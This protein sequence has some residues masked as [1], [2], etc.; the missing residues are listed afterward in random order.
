MPPAQGG[1]QASPALPTPIATPPIANI[2]AS[3]AQVAEMYAQG[4]PVP[5]GTRLIDPVTLLEYGQ[6]DGAGGYQLTSG[7]ITRYTAAQLSAL[8]AAGGLT[9]YATYVESD[10]GIWR[11]AT[12][13]T[14][15]VSFSGG[16]G[17][18]ADPLTLENGAFS[19]TFTGPGGRFSLN[20]QSVWFPLRS[21]MPGVAG[22]RP[23]VNWFLNSS[24]PG[25]PTAWDLAVDGLADTYAA[26]T[27]AHAGATIGALTVTNAASDGGP[28]EQGYAGNAYGAAA[29]APYAP[30]QWYAYNGVP[31]GSI[32]TMRALA[33]TVTAP[34][35][36]VIYQRFRDS[37]IAPTESLGGTITLSAS[38]QTFTATME[39]NHNYPALQ[40]RVNLLA[41]GSGD[42]RLAHV[43]LEDLTGDKGPL[44]PGEYVPS[45]ASPGWQWFSTAKGTSC[46]NS[47]YTANHA[48][49]VGVKNPLI[50]SA[51][52][53]GVLTD[54]TGARL[55]GITG[56]VSEPAATNIATGFNTLASIGVAKASGAIT[57]FPGV[58][59]A[60]GSTTARYEASSGQM[61]G[62]YNG[63]S[64]TDITLTLNGVSAGNDSIDSTTTNFV[65]AGFFVGMTI[66]VWRSDTL[67]FGPMPVASVT[68]TKIGLTGTFFGSTRASGA[69]TRILRCPGNGDNI[70]LMLNDGTAHHTTLASAVTLPS[71]GAWD[72]K[73]PV[74]M[75]LAAAPPSNG[76][77]ASTDNGT[78]CYYWKDHT[79]FGVSFTG[80]T[81][82]TIKPVFDRAALVEAGLGYL[83][84][85]GLALEINSGTSGFAT[86][87]FGATGSLGTASRD[88]QISIWA[89]R[90]AGASTW[91]LKLESHANTVALTD[92]TWTKRAVQQTSA[93]A[94][95]RPA[96]VC[97]SGGS[98]RLYV[99]LWSTEQ[100]SGASDVAVRSSPI[101]TFG[102]TTGTTRATTRCSRAWGGSLTNNIG[103]LLTW[104]PAWGALGS[105]QKQTLWSLYADASN[106]LEL[107]ISG[108]TITWRKRRG[109]TNY[110]CTASY[111]PVAGVSVDLSFACRSDTGLTLSVAGVAATP[112]TTDLFDITALTPAALEEVGSLNGASVAYGAFKAL[113]I[114]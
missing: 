25:A 22:A 60:S 43:Q 3:A 31:A 88:T 91:S 26:T 42:A 46:T 40:T 94:Q 64:P 37:A 72:S 113:D 102:A 32:M 112:V 49:L 47:T 58:P 70:M 89:K 13:A 12:S 62:N 63:T 109:G 1:L 59:F 78:K 84:P 53:A 114:I 103:R 104:T 68:A 45:G 23:V 108:T 93:G 21:N 41:P 50:S 54:A 10:T 55:T 52:A 106:Y 69:G 80:G 111:T 67:L 36:W 57:G 90:V 82:V 71:A 5:K 86:V 101:V 39:A 96:V 98:Q 16:I 6:S 48:A 33:R 15:L 81:G 95:N 65:T 77:W 76:G 24:T 79:D 28:Y 44:I 9:R 75:T 38:F 51:N 8:A 87:T 19:F 30:G 11:R 20:H 85:H 105:S 61:I 18:A 2:V 110:D 27:D 7:P 4:T 73:A 34:T 29:S 14:T 66:W 83:C 100:A 17:G 92:A 74:T 99:I 97:P 35:S 107:S 56:I